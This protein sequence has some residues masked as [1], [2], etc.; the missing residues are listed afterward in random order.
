MIKDSVEVLP[1]F[2]KYWSEEQKK[3]F[4]QIIDEE[5]L[6]ASKT[7]K[8]IEDY[9]LAEKKPLR[10]EVL[11]LLEGEKPSLLQRKKLGAKI[12]NPITDFVE[13]FIEGMA[14]RQY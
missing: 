14:G 8:L 4:D 11:E 7:E 2:E 5:N 13:T 12:L 1:E 9:L 6:S 3:A 10:D